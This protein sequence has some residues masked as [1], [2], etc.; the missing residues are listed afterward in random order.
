VKHLVSIA[1]LLL[2]PLVT[3]GCTDPKTQS[4]QT[5][6]MPQSNTTSAGQTDGVVKVA[7]LTDGTVI[8]NAETVPIDSLASKLDSLGDIKEIWYHREAPDAAGPHENA[9][10]TI[11]E[12]A[13]RK[14]PIAMYLDRAFTQRATFAQ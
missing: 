5:N 2:V 6:P 8:V 14:R 10:K 1:V 12:L 4:E 7:V 13:N 9:M 11:E 3:A